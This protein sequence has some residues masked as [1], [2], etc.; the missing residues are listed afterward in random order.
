MSGRLPSLLPVDLDEPQRKLYDSLV[1][2]ELGWADR[3]RFQV[4]ATDGSLLGPFN[5][6]LF[7]PVLGTAWMGV[8]RTDKSHTSLSPRVHEVVVLTVGAGWN[9]GYE[10]YAHAAVAKATGLS[11]EGIEAIVAGQPPDFQSE[12]EAIAHEFTWQ[13]TQTHRVPSDLYTRAS[14]VLGREV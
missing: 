1:A 13:L 12:E 11:D 4:I 3:S 2:N 8:F 5:P 9:S 14:Q 10:L 6:L 7:S